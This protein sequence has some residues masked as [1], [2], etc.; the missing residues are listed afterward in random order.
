LLQAARE[1]DE[2]DHLGVVWIGWTRARIASDVG[3]T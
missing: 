2:L 3:K 1:A